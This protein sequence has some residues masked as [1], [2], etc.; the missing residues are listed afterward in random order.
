MKYA[1]I[2]G[3]KAL[4]LQQKCGALAEGYHADFFTIDLS[5]PYFLNFNH[6]SLAENLILGTSVEGYI[7]STCINGYLREYK[8]NLFDHIEDLSI[9]KEAIC[10]LDGSSIENFLVSMMK[11]P[12]TTGSEGLLVF[13]GFFIE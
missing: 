2:N 10:E 7:S 8:P 4:G 11:I 1:T 13:S 9:K 5:D 12:S 6:E 3:A